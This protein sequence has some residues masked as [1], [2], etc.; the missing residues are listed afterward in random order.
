MPT[1]FSFGIEENKL[2]EMPEI[3][4][5]RLET[6]IVKLGF[7]IVAATQANIR[8]H[9][10]IDTGN[11]INSVFLDRSKL[12]MLSVDIIVGAPYGIYHEL[13]TVHLPAKPFLGPAIEAHRPVLAQ[14]IK[15]VFRDFDASGAAA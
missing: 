5:Q 8:A 12:Y 2:P 11:L 6:V 9:D 13:G 7:D 3:I 10:L 14:V 1:K 15:A 4:H